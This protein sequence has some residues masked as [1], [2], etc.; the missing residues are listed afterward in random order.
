MAK[1]VALFTKPEDSRISGEDILASGGQALSSSAS[2]HASHGTPIS[3]ASTASAGR[4]RRTR[5]EGKKQRRGDRLRG[6]QR[7]PANLEVM[8]DIDLLISVRLQPA[9]LR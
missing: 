6:S 9:I 2:A 3:P 8:S 5:A 7:S 1:M 4:P